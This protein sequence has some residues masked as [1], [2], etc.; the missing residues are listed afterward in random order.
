MRRLKLDEKVDL[1]FGPRLAL[2]FYA[3]C[4]PHALQTARLHKGAIFVC[5]GS[6]L[7]EEGLG[8]GVPV[9]RYQDGTRFPMSADTFLE[10][11]ENPKLV[12]I[13][14]MN[15]IA[16]KRFRGMPIRRGSSLARILKAL[17]KGYRGLRRLR[18][19]A[20]MMLDIISMLG[21]RNEYLES[22]SKGQVAVTYRLSSRGL[23]IEAALGELSK[24][25]LHSIVF[26]NEQ[27]GRLFSEYEDSTGKR[28]HDTQIEAWRTV[29]AE[30]ASLHSRAFNVGFRLNRPSRWL[31]ARGREVV[32]DRF[33]WSGLDLFCGE[34]P[35][36]LEYSVEIV[37]ES[38]D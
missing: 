27:G 25:G 33:S 22:R 34:L 3:D 28:L 12:K 2:R 8:I 6:E 23:E 26:A 36:T 32:R 18:T 15:G 9:C 14:D 13:Y 24:E 4:R 10:D 21:M 29:G 37:G 38:A 11:S 16:S 31:M 1:K 35:Q 17:E 30:W 5:N 20:T 7:V 19:E